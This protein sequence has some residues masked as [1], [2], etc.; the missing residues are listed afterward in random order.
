M[1]FLLLGV[2][3]SFAQRSV[4][5]KITDP[6]GDPLIGANITVK[7]APAIGTVTDVDGMYALVVP[8]GAAGLVISY[9]GFETREM[10]LGSSDVLNIVLTEGTI[11]DEIVVTGT[12]VATGRKSLAFDVQ[13]LSSNKLPIAPTADI[14]NALIGKIAGAQISSVNGSPGRPINILLRGVNSIRGGTSPMI[15]MDGI[16][17]ASTDL[18]NL[19]LNNVER[20]EVVSG[21]AAASL[22]GAQGAN[23]VIQLFSKKG[24]DGLLNIDFS[25]NF[26]VNELLNIGG[27]NKA[28]K[29]AFAVNAAGE[30][31]D[32]SGN[33]MEFDSETGSYLSN[34]IF[35]LIS[36]TSLTNQSYGKNLTW[37]DHYKMF[38][39]KANVF[40]NSLSVNGSTDKFN[41]SFVLSDNKQETVFKNNG[42]YRRSNVSAD[43]GY[44]L[45]KG[46]TFR[47]VTQLVNVQSTLLDPSG[48]NMFYAINNSRPFAN[49]E[50]R[51]AAGLYSPYYG[52][53]VGVNSYN[54]NYIIENAQVKDHTLDVIQSFNLNYKLNKF[55]ELDAKYGLN[56]SAQNVRYNIAEQSKSVGA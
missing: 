33:P 36:P 50:Q 5:G 7:D 41:F 17:V 27:V 22:Y 43:V 48:R 19:D 1:L 14:G 37:Y 26:A 40:N 53:A 23:G 8:D 11:L 15:M 20:I 56:R 30:V 6:S 49:Y 52:D 38:F 28:T 34:P 2:S 10:A 31:I 29:H 12:G 16:Q 25:T 51:D 47:S 13:A 18:Q 9:T 32:A 46:M 3:F 4:T 54:F 39:Q 42:D 35:N 44:E 24:K 21:P 55:V 45:F